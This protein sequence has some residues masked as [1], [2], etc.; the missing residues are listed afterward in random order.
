MNETVATAVAEATTEAVAT[1]AT[2]TGLSKVAKF[3]I[4]GAAVAA[5]AGATTFF[6]LKKKNKKEDKKQ[7]EDDDIIDGEYYDVTEE[8]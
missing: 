6:V 7:V 4:L 3:G 1:Q 8:Q 2:K 5:V